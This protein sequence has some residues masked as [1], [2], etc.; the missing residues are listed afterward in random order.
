MAV[1]LFGTISAVSI[2]VFLASGNT[3]LAMSAIV[4]MVLCGGYSRMNMI[5][6]V[7]SNREVC[8]FRSRSPLLSRHA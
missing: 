5:G 8:L 7:S 3:A 1:H 2:A 4:L 6:F